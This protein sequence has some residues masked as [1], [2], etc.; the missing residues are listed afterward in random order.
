MYLEESEWLTM[1]LEWKEYHFFLNSTEEEDPHLELLIETTARPR[2]P[3]TRRMVYTNAD[4]CSTRGYYPMSL[5]SWW[6]SALFSQM[7]IGDRRSHSW[8]SGLLRIFHL[9]ILCRSSRPT[10]ARGWWVAQMAKGYCQESLGGA[11]SRPRHLKLIPMQLSPAGTRGRL[12]SWTCIINAELNMYH[13]CQ[14]G[15]KLDDW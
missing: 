3:N 9:W 12:S 5:F 6:W 2:R 4:T 13:L 8:W 15:Q 14:H 1:I 10:G 11:G 7:R